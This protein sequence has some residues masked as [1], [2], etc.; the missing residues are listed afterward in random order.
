VVG[1][2]FDVLYFQNYAQWPRR[3][4][5][6]GFEQ[7]NPVLYSTNPAQPVAAGRF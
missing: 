1:A 3:V 7:A 6:S 5:L 4:V 2:L